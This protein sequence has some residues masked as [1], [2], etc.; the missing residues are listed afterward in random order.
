MLR[1]GLLELGL[2]GLEDGLELFGNGSDSSSDDDGDEL[3]DELKLLELGLAELEDELELL[4][5]GDELELGLLDEELFKLT[6]G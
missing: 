1:L 2:A 4:E 3:E 5:L 6:A